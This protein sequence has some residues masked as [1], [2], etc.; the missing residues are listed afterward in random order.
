MLFNKS[1]YFSV[2]KV[3][4]SQYQISFDMNISTVFRDLLYVQRNDKQFVLGKAAIYNSDGIPFFSDFDKILVAAREAV[5]KVYKFTICDHFQGRYDYR[6]C[7]DEET[8]R[9]YLTNIITCDQEDKEEST[10]VVTNNSTGVEEAGSATELLALYFPEL[11]IRTPVQEPSVSPMS[12]VL[13]MQEVLNE[14]R[15]IIQ[16]GTDVEKSNAKAIL[17]YVATKLAKQ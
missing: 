17:A 14:M 6:F 9:M 11:S 12:V 15:P 5:D 16:N 10:L 13:D 7:A 2:P 8:L 1:N 4:G 3:S